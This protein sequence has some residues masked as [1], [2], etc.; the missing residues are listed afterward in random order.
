MSSKCLP[1]VIPNVTSKNHN[2]N[3][4]QSSLSLSIRVSCCIHCVICTFFSCFYQLFLCFT[5]FGGGPHCL[6]FDKFCVVGKQNNES[7][8]PSLTYVIPC[9]SFYLQGKP[10]RLGPS[11]GYTLCMMRFC[12]PTTEF[13]THE[14]HADE[15]EETT[16]TLPPLLQETEAADKLLRKPTKFEMMRRFKSRRTKRKSQIIHPTHLT[17]VTLLAWL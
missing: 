11:H 3:P 16:T 8:S 9:S 1:S 4:F 5:Q 2:C 13:H 10:R 12:L 14:I 6:N 7:V 17:E 15:K